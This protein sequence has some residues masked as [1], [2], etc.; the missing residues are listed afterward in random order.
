MWWPSSKNLLEAGLTSKPGMVFI[1]SWS[2]NISQPSYALVP[3]PPL[4]SALL[5]PIWLAW[6]LVIQETETWEWLQRR[7]LLTSQG[8]PRQMFSLFRGSQQ[9][10]CK[11]KDQ[12][13]M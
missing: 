2:E 6:G 7:A 1:S 3:P 12:I 4:A 9:G 10:Q 5:G 8:K 11:F 13:C